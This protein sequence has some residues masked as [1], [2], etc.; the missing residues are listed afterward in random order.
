[1]YAVAFFSGA[2]TSSFSHPRMTC[3][4]PDFVSFYN[5]EVVFKAPTFHLPKYNSKIKNTVREK[6]DEQI[7][8]FFLVIGN[9]LKMGMIFRINFNGK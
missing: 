9:I 5:G 4:I 2:D 1:M 6:R 7:V 8:E 3:L